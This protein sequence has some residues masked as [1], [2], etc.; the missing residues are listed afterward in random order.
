MTIGPNPISHS[1]RMKIAEEIA[2]QLQ[3]Y[4]KERVLAISIYGSLAKGTDGPYSDIEMDCVLE[5]LDCDRTLEWCGGDWKAE[6]DLLSVSSVLKNAAE[7]GPKWP[8]SHG[9]YIHY[10]PVY[11]PT[12][13]YI[14]RRKTA[15]S[16]PDLKFRRAM[17]EL[18]VDEMFE[19]QGKILNAGCRK[20]YTSLPLYAVLQARWGALLI[21]LANRQLYSTSAKIFSESLKLDGRPAGYDDLCRLVMSGALSE[22]ERILSACE[23][24]WAGVNQWAQENGIRLVDD[25]EDLLRHVASLA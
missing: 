1:Q 19:I 12:N 11:D 15:L 16:Q 13:L 25:L 6:I 9:I 17:R 5:S 20:D 14:H 7:V 8:I 3:D 23:A 2:G 4:F 18:I 24:F 10:I 21:G 22:P